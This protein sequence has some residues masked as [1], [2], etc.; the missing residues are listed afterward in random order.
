MKENRERYLGLHLLEEDDEFNKYLDVKSPDDIPWEVLNSYYKK[1]KGHDMW[2]MLN[3][4]SESKEMF[5]KWG[6]NQY[7][8][9]F[10]K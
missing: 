7:S 10:K 9:Q 5:E 2:Q 1:S 6:L 4:Y 3:N 8:L